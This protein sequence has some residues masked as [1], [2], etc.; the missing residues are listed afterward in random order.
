MQRL[1]VI[2]AILDHHGEYKRRYV[3]TC[4]QSNNALYD[5]SLPTT[6]ELLCTIVGAIQDWPLI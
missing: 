1:L 5:S 2:R 3:G 4:V 6:L